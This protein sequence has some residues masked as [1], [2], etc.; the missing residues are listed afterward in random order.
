MAARTNKVVVPVGA[1]L[2]GYLT[3]NLDREWR[4]PLFITPV[5]AGIPERIDDPSENEISLLEYLIKH[6]A[7][8][9]AVPASG[10]S[11]LG[12]GIDPGDL[13]IVDSAVEANRNDIVVASVD[14]ECTVKRLR[15]VGGH[16]WLVPDSQT[17]KGPSVVRGQQIDVL[18]VVTFKI[19]KM[20]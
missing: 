3:L 17:Y 20:R 2:K 11:M 8:T 18:G 19:T 16:L 15:E 13:L 7:S 1:Q 10:D 9:F 6:P 12:A 4:I 5:Q 14:G